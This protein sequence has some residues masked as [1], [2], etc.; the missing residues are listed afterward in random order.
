LLEKLLERIAEAFA[1]MHKFTLSF[2]NYC[3]MRKGV[4]ILAMNFVLTLLVIDWNDGNYGI[5]GIQ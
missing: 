1:N 5:G 4:E 2:L 3:E